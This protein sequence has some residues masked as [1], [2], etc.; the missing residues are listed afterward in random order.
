MIVVKV[1]PQNQQ[2]EELIFEA[3]LKQL[4]QLQPS[5]TIDLSNS[6]HMIQLQKNEDGHFSIVNA[7]NGYGENCK[8]DLENDN[9]VICSDLQHQTSIWAEI[10]AERNFQDNK[11]GIRTMDPTLWLPILG[12]EVGEVNKAVVE[13]IFDKADKQNL[14]DELIQVAAVALAM[15]EDLDRQNQQ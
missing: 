11:W 12:E 3:N 8:K 6:S 14:R 7:M 13:I 5:Q 9:V 10:L 2:S 1:I 4:V 15:I